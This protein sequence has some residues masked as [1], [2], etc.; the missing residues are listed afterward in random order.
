MESVLVAGGA[1][2]IGSNL[3]RLLLAR[4]DARVVVLDR[5]T[6]AGNL[7]SLA[8]V[9]EH[10]RFSFVQGDIADRAGDQGKPCRR[11]QLKQEISFAALRWRPAGMGEGCARPAARQSG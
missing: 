7:A 3:V 10:P 4:T 11:A 5:L 9:R 2:F 1:G 6:Y 8:D